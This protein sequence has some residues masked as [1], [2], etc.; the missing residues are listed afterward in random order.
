MVI[1]I[2]KAKV[3]K[4]RVFMLAFSLLEDVFLVVLQIEKTAEPRKT[5]II[6]GLVRNKI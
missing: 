3:C 4:D 1:I 2:A 5:K 6:I